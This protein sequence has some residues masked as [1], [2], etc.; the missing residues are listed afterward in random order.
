MAKALVTGATGFI[1]SQLCRKLV[2]LGAEVHAVSRNPPNE[3]EVWWRSAGGDISDAALAAKIRWWS[4][5]LTDFTAT[6]K[7]IRTIRPEVT[8]HLASQV[9]GSRNIE[10]VLP[11]L[12]NNFVSAVNLLL[13]AAEGST[14]RILLA[15]S[16]EEPE[17]VDPVPCSP[18]AA[19]KWS[20][21]SYARMFRA[22]YQVDVVVAKIF[23][24]YGP[25]QADYTKLIPYVITTLLRGEAPRLT[26]GLR[27]LDWIYVDDVVNGLIASA[28][29]PPTDDRPIDLGSGQEYSIREIVKQLTNL[30]PGAPEPLFE[31]LPDRP[32]ERL[33]KSDIGRSHNLIGWGPS[34][35]LESGL[36]RTVEWYKRC[37]F[38]NRTQGSGE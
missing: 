11:L 13:A 28:Q 33:G 15:G 16:F 31:A 9:T 1:G 5:N 26:S 18:Y 8:Y 36:S 20:A 7:L 3:L 10:M 34:T 35:I 23:M 4:A 12:Q 2:V 22:L 38:W 6:R 30:I 19:A 27:M 24:V 21:S 29:G 14:H 17:G 32:L 37:M 25:G